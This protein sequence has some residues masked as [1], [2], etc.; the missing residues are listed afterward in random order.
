MVGVGAG[1]LRGRQ[2]AAAGPLA[3]PARR[4]PRP[5]RR[6]VGGRAHRGRRAPTPFWIGADPAWSLRPRRLDDRGDAPARRRSVT[7]ALSHHRRRRPSRSPT[8]PTAIAPLRRRS[9]DPPAAVADRA[10]AATWSSPSDSRERLGGDVQIIDPPV[11]LDAAIG[12]VRRRSSSS[13]PCASTRSSPP[14]R[15]ERGRS[16]SAHEPKLAGLSRRLEQ[17]SVPVARAR[18]ASSPPRVQQALART[19]ADRPPTSADEAAA[20]RTRMQ[21][22]RLLLDDGDLDEPSRLVGAARCRRKRHVVSA[23]AGASPAH[24]RRPRAGGRP[25]LAVM[26]APARGRGRQPAVRGRRSPGCSTPATTPASS[27]SSPCSCCC[28]F[29]RRPSAPPG[30]SSPERLELLT[31]TSRRGRRRRRGWRSSPAAD[32]WRAAT[33][34]PTDRWSSLLGL[35]APAAG[36]LG[37][38]PAGSP[39]ATSAL[40]RVSASLVVEP[41]VRLGV[42]VALAVLIGPLGAAIGAVLSRLR[43]PGRVRHRE[44]R[45]SHRSTPRGAGR[46]HDAAATIGRVVRAAGRAC[47]RSTCSSPTAC[48]T[49]DEAGA[50]RRALDDRRGG[51]LRHGDDPARADAGRSRQGRQ[52]RPDGVRPDGRHRPRRSPRSPRCS[53]RPL[54]ERRVRRRV[55]ATSPASSGRTCWRWRCSGVVRVR[56]GPPRRDRRAATAATAT[57]IAIAAAAIARGGGDRPVGRPAPT[58]SSRSRCSRSP[59]SRSSSSCPHVTRWRARRRFVCRSGAAGGRSHGVLLAMVALCVVAAAIRVATSRGLWVDEAISVRQAQ[60]PFGQMLADVR[61][62]RR[63]SAAPPR[64]AVGDGAGV[65]NVGVRGALAVADRRRRSRAGDGLGRPPGL[66]PAHRMGRG[67]ARGGRAVRRVVLAGSADVLAV[68]AVR[69]RSRWAPRCRRSGAAARRDWALYGVATAAMIWTQ[70]FAVLPGARAA[71][72]RSSCVLWRDRHD[73]QTGAGGCCCA[74]GCCSCAVVGGGAAAAAADPASTSSPRTATGAPASTPGQAGAGSS[75]IGG[76]ISIYAVGA[77]LIWATL[78]YHADGVMV[79]LAALWPLL[80]LLA[81][82]MLG[83]GRSGRS[84]LPA[85][86][87]GRADDGA[88]RRRLDEARP[89]R[90][91]LLRRRRAGAAAARRPRRHRDHARGAARSCS[92]PRRLAAAL[93]GR[94]RRPAAQRRQPAALR[95]RGGARRDRRATPSRATSCSTSP[96][97]RRGGRLLRARRRCAARSAPTCRPDDRT[98]FVLATERVINAEDTAARLGHELAVLEQHATSSTSSN[99]RTSASGSCMT[100]RPRSRCQRSSAAPRRSHRASS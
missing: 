11:D 19:T 90:A 84:V 70:Y 20:S 64:P 68:H 87:R 33:G 17:V 1:D 57:T 4:P 49:I 89:V 79:Q 71:G 78:G 16:P 92:A 10:R 43:R 12:D 82:V 100:P 38:Q 60:L 32:R 30:R 46:R 95:L 47:S 15:P 6:G 85:R 41:A 61:D 69:R 40:G 98:V 42:G 93:S 24:W 34:L 14:A 94:A 44:P 77:N 22:L 21:L 72:R 9:R 83:R 25:Q 37:P 74:A 8:W 31:T 66:R 75:T 58:P 53:P 86:A 54:V 62:D 91:A 81:L 2:A 67:G 52:R 39:T 88:V 63:A 28:T 45:R 48:S 80:M 3:R 96:V 36:L 13:S 35:A 27:R 56:G 65:R 50:L 5:A 18:R 29:R 73:R 76:S 7:V 97:P 51:V 55:R 59:R 23:P 99:V 26:S